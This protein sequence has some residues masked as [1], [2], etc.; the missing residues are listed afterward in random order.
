MAAQTVHY[1]AETVKPQSK[2]YY[3]ALCYSL[4]ESFGMSLYVFLPYF[5]YY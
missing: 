5:I 1:T 3:F 2:D 4:N